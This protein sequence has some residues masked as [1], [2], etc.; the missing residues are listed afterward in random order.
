MKDA[1]VDP[2]QQNMETLRDFVIRARR[3]EAHSLASDLAALKAYASGNMT[4]ELDREAGKQYLSQ[5]LP[6]EEVVESAAARVRPLILQ[7]DP[8]Y[9]AK[10]LKAIGFLTREYESN[11]GEILS[12]LKAYWQ[13]VNPK[14][15]EARGYVLL[16]KSASDE[17][18]SSIIDSDLGMSWFYGDVVHADRKRREAGAK[19]GIDERY[20]AAVMLV[21]GNMMCAKMTLDFIR[22]LQKEELVDLPED[23]FT[24]DV[25]VSKTHFRTETTAYVGDVGTPM[26]TDISDDFPEGFEPFDPKAHVPG[27]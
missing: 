19:F 2:R 6:P 22:T 8:V 1:N 15:G 7:E 24:E 12:H 26:P 14:P 20:R 3:I 13:S 5:T 23:A 4:L 17:D 21:S 10:A 25:V 11:I 27:S 18:T 9:W 16:L